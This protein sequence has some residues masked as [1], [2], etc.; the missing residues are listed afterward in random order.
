MED[1]AVQ[2]TPAKIT[3]EHLEEE[4]RKQ[5]LQIVDKHSNLFRTEP[6]RTDLIEHTIQLTNS[7]PIRQP[8]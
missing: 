4:Q 8:Y 5:L 6:G 1:V 7:T 2:R 3:L